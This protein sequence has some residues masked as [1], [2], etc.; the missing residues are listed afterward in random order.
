MSSLF[1][2]EHDEPIREITKVPAALPSSLPSSLTCSQTCLINKITVVVAWSCVSYLF[3]ATQWLKVLC[4]AEEA[5]HYLTTFKQFE[6]R[7]PDMI[8][9]RIDQDYSS[10]LRA[11]LT[12][13]SKVNKTDVE[14]LR[15]SF[16]VR[17][18]MYHRSAL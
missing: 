11:A 1:Q 14:T 15:T 4:R 16:G 6:H 8:K 7:P 17:A 3:P 18:H 10:V 9:E 13:I 2:N 12:S 5:G